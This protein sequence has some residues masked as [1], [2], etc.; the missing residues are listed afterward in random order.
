MGQAIEWILSKQQ[1]AA[2]REIDATAK[3]R[4]HRRF[5]DAV[6]QLSKAYA[7][8]SA[9]EEAKA[10]RDEV[11]FF[12]AIRASLVKST[13]GP[14]PGSAERDAAIAQLIDRSV[15]STEI[16]DIL[17]AAGISSPDISILSDEFLAE[18]AQTEQKNLALEALRKLLNDQVRSRSKSN[19]TES[20]KFSERLEDAIA[21]YHTNAISTVEVLQA[22]IDLAK[23]VRAAQARG[24]EEGLSQD[25]LA[26][27]GRPGNNGREFPKNQRSRP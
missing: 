18:I 11:G 4:I 26:F 15:V 20:R 14:G 27:Y 3:K 16:V 7:L 24:E 5:Q 13:T 10:I 8:A 9:S 6:L 25:E 22:L 23:D 1:Q 19:V 17:G 2:A 21:R 12:Q